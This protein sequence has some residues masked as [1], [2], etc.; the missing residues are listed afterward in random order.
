VFFCYDLVMNKSENKNTGNLGEDIT[1]KYLEKKGY[2]ILERNYELFLGEIDILAEYKKALII[3]EVKTVRGS[4]FGL[5]QD[6][7]R[8]KKQNKLRSL[9][10][11]L[12]QEHPNRT[13]K[14]DVVG[15]DASDPKNPIIEHIKNAVEN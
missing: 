14:I 4:G 2:K 6:L 11:V 1:E 12:E 9:A 5:A 15:V 3:V 10:R 13:I 7:V 8:Y